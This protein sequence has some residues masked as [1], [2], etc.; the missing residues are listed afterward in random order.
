MA[1][2]VA[3]PV[4]L[5]RELPAR[6]NYHSCSKIFL[7]ALAFALAVVGYLGDWYQ[8]A[9]TNQVNTVHVEKIH[10]YLVSTAAQTDVVAE[11]WSDANSPALGALFAVTGKLLIAAIVVLGVLFLVMVIGAF[12]F[13]CAE[14]AQGRY[15]ASP[16]WTFI[17]MLLTITAAALLGA[18][19]INFMVHHPS[20]YSSDNQDLCQQN[21]PQCSTFMD[22]GV[23]PKYAW[24]SVLVS[25]CIAVWLLGQEYSDL[26]FCNTRKQ[27]YGVN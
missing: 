9:F 7:T 27:V 5:E 2:W 3:Q 15:V 16:A 22:D 1:V 11:S 14:H 26:G 12:R 21:L 8:Y 20:A 13:C 17:E 25:F 18:V 10:Q 6:R 4:I 19:W 23:D 24:I